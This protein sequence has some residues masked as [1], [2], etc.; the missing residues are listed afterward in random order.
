MLSSGYYV[1]L[2]FVQ[3]KAFLVSV[4]LRIPCK[5][6]AYDILIGS[7]EISVLVLCFNNIHSYEKI[8]TV[9]FNS[10][11]SSSPL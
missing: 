4:G 7:V 1:R 6:Q 8:C 11:K 5:L 2:Q 9:E 3:T 10:S